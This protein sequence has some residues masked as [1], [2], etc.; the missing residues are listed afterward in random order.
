MNYHQPRQIE[1]TADRPD[2]G[3]WRY[4]NM[5]DGRVWTEGYWCHSANGEERCGRPEKEG[6][7][8]P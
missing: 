4:T 7:N 5:N 1:P 6:W 8:R 3:K 2:A